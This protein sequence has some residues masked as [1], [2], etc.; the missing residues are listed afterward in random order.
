MLEEVLWLYDPSVARQWHH[1]VHL[2]PAVN[3]NNWDKID[4]MLPHQYQRDVER[5]M[6]EEDLRRNY[7]HV[8][9]ENWSMYEKTGYEWKKKS[10]DQYSANACGPSAKLNGLIL[11]PSYVNRGASL[12]NSSDIN[13]TIETCKQR[14]Y[15]RHRP[16]NIPCM[17][18]VNCRKILPYQV[19]Q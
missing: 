7:A 17:A 11:E 19:A 9:L 15:S 13:T 2:V 8:E 12:I 14:S 6:I 18:F 5:E 1:K 16:I 4:I 10:N 3:T